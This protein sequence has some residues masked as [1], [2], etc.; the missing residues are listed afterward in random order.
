MKVLLKA[1]AL[2]EY[3]DGAN[4]LL[5]ELDEEQAKEILAKRELLQMVQSRSKGL[6]ALTF[7]GIPGEFYDVDE[8]A[9]LDHLGELAAKFE[10]DEYVVVPDDFTVHAFAFA[11]FVGEDA[12]EEEALADDD[13]ICVR[14]EIDLMLVIDRGVY[15]RAALKHSS[16]YVESSILPFKFLLPKEASH[17]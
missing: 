8:D 2:H 6:Y 11:D 16:T 9:L 5:L 15:F 10:I 14:T 13:E 17:G 3:L 12:D 4:C 7:R 1:T